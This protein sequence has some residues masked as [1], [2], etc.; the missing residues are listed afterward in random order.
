MSYLLL[1]IIFSTLQ[2]ME[3]GEEVIPTNISDETPTQANT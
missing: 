2:N 1:F 3:S